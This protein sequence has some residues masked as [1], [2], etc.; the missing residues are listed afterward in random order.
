[1][2]DGVYIAIA[3][4]CSEATYP[5]G[6]QRPIKNST[7]I[8]PQRIKRSELVTLVTI[9]GQDAVPL[10]TIRLVPLIDGVGVHPGLFEC[11]ILA[12]QGEAGGE[13]GSI[14]C[15]RQIDRQLP[16]V[17]TWDPMN[18]LA[19]VRRIG[20]LEM[21]RGLRHNRIALLPSVG[22]SNSTGL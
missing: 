17:G 7:T 13:F 6:P 20:G 8:T 9:R 5:V 19:S 2:V 3:Y 15:R 11:I 12:R 1:M 18:L 10:G 16:C 14:R 21:E 4:S 22:D